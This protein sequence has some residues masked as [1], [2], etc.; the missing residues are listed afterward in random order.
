MGLWNNSGYNT[1]NTGW[2][3]FASPLKKTWSV[4]M[5]TFPIYEKTCSKAPISYSL[6]N[7]YN[8]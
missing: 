4:G 6:L 1:N 2:C 8:G 7:E 5:M 3:F